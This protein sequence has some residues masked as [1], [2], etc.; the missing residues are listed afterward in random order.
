MY[1]LLNS[2]RHTVGQ[3]SRI[4]ELPFAGSRC[5]WLAAVQ[6][7]GSDRIG[8]NRHPWQTDGCT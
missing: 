5:P 6:P 4:V 1:N 8:L 3:I 2:Y 7:L